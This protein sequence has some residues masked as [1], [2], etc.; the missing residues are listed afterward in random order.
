MG[1][2]IA[3]S[4]L[5]AGLPVTLLDQQQAALDRGMKPYPQYPD[6]NVASGRT[7]REAA[8]KAFALLKPSLSYEDLSTADLIIEAAYENLEIKQTIFKALDAVAK[9]EAILAT[10]TSYLDVN[11]IAAMTGRPE[12]V[13]GLHFFSPANVMKLL[14]VVRTDHTSPVVLASALK[15][16]KRIGKIA[17]VARVC[18]GFIGNRMLAVRRR[19][20][21]QMILGAQT[22]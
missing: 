20:C 9:P 4:L 16:A 22:L 2:G 15:L 21:D 12:Y 17:V 13:L 5:L 10:N 19:E 7:S 18:Y 8:D 11:E 14:E 3:I 1:S 6:R